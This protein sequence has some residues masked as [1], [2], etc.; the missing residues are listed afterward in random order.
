MKIAIEGCAHGDLENIYD[1]IYVLEQKEGIKIDLLICCGDFQSSRNNDDLT[2]MAVPLKY[3]NICTF[4]KYYS[5]EKVAPIL[6]IFIGGNHEASNYLQE[7]PYGGWVAPNIYYMGYAGVINVGGLRIAGVSGIY[8][9]QDYWKG[10]YEKPPYTDESKRSVYHVRNL[11]IFRLKQLSGKIDVMISHDWPN[12]ITKYGN[13]KQLLKKK[14]LFKE[15]IEKNQLG[16]QPNTDLLFH[17]K[18][19]YWFAAH[20]HCKFSAVVRHK[21]DSMTRFLAL[22]K[23]LPK[24]KFLQV[25]DIPHNGDS[26][27]EIAYDLEWMSILYLTNHLLSV[28]STKNYMPGP[29]STER[30]EF[31]PTEQEKTNVMKRFRDNLVVPR[32]FSKTAVAYS[33]NSKKN[34]VKQPEPILN[35][36]TVTLCEILA[37]DDP[38]TLISKMEGTLEHLNSSLDLNS[39][40]SFIDDSQENESLNSSQDTPTKKM[41]NLTLP[42]PKV[43][44]DDDLEDI[45]EANEDIKNDS[46]EVEA[47]EVKTESEDTKIKTLVEHM[48]PTEDDCKSPVIKKLRRR[49]EELYK[50]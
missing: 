41:F 9:G 12:E 48:L 1:T 50:S 8:K 4:Y 3:R 24:R 36:Q 17:L 37:I 21:D 32:I 39:T 40:I 45:E 34:D 30:Y 29:G 22:D 44:L 14:P 19:A 18:P 33:P 13:V 11:E 10:H 16:S 28:K 23:C 5:G 7:L 47:T 6:T 20:L 27:I 35:P 25:L 31:T 26:K 2:C 43:D 46:Q 49:N 42:D 38:L 15:D